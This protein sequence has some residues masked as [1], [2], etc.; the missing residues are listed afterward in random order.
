[1]SHRREHP[2]D[3]GLHASIRE[4]EKKL[5]ELWLLRHSLLRRGFSVDGVHERVT[6][7]R[8]LLPMHP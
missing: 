3:D 6:A 1:M 2:N 4:A 8:F 5:V 7:P